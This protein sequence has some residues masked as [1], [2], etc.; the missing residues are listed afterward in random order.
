MAL[1]YIS[2]IGKQFFT[3]KNEEGGLYGSY[4]TTA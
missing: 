4:E 3:N 1:P 2:Y